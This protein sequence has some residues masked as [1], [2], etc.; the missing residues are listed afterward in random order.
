[1]ELFMRLHRLVPLVPAVLLGCAELPTAPPPPNWAFA[2]ATPSSGSELRMRSE[3][4][5]IQVT[6]DGENIYGP[7]FNLKHAGTYIRG[8][9]TGNTVIDVQLQGTHAVGNVKNA[10]F[11]IDMS[12]QGDG[13]T[14]VTGLFGGSISNFKISPNLF[15]GRVGVCNYEVNWTGSR[16]EGKVSCPTIQQ[17]SLELPVAMAS[18]TD[19]EVATLLGIVLGT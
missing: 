19:L 14:Q 5:Y 16:Y 2:S 13:V 3:S 4:S 7:N 12:P 18:W 6:I 11:T 10:P 17:G 9:G 15:N 1:L 8:T